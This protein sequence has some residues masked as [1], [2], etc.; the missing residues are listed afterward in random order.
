[1]VAI[2]PDM[3][4]S[5][6]TQRAA[7][8]PQVANSVSGA[9]KMFPTRRTNKTVRLQ[10][11]DQKLEARR[12]RTTRALNAD[13]FSVFTPIFVAEPVSEIH[14]LRWTSPLLVAEWSA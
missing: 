7:N 12:R 10:S 3:M 5:E 9:L 8:L 1:M 2:T 14:P 6:T 4:I 13:G 11:V